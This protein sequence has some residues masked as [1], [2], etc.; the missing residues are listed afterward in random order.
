MSNL[1]APLR[2]ACPECGSANIDVLD[3]F[4]M[5]EGENGPELTDSGQCYDCG[6]SWIDTFS[7][8]NTEI[9]YSNTDYKI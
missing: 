7:L 3:G 5:Q 8:V 1:E 4:A 9:D 2:D 6:I